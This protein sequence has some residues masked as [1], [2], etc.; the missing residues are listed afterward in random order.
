M[1]RTKFRLQSF[2]IALS[3]TLALFAFFW[4]VQLAPEARAPVALAASA[5]ALMLAAWG[6][7]WRGVMA[8]ITGRKRAE[9]SLQ[10]AHEALRQAN[11]ALA[12]IIHASP[13]AIFA[14]DLEG[15]VT[16]W[17]PAAER[18]FGWSREEALGRRL[19]LVED[20]DLAVF[21]DRI[22]RGKRGLRM[23][24]LEVTQR[25]K[26]GSSVTISMWTAP[27]RGPS[28]A[29]TGFIGLAADASERSLL[30]ERLRQSQKME[31]VGRLAGGVAHDF[32][33]LLTVITGYG[34]MLLDEI[35]TAESPRASV[36]E[37]LRTVERASALTSQLLTFSRHQVAQPVVLDLTSAVAKMD[38]ML[39]RVIGED[40]ELVAELSSQLG[41]VRADPAQIEQVILNLVVNARDAM[42]AG[43]R[44]AIR[45]A[46]L[47]IRPEDAL[48]HPAVSPGHYVLLSVADTG[49]GMDD[50]TKA[51]MF[52]PFFTT[53][54]HGK[55]TGLGM[56][57]VYAI[58]KRNAGEI[59]V[60]SQPG[61]G[62]TISI[63]LPRV[64]DLPE[65]PQEPSPAVCHERGTETILL[66][67][68]E[69]AV[70]KLVHEV[71]SQ[72]GYVVLQASRPEE[73]L[74]HSRRHPGKIDLLLTD[75]VMPHMSGRELAD[76]LAPAR[77]DM[78]VLF[79]SGYTEDAVVARCPQTALL[80]KPFTPA[81]LAHKVRTI[82]DNRP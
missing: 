25:R 27:L 2:L 57:T 82:L 47:E 14:F 72:H 11:E 1:L 49:Q 13:L 20:R 39:R 6:L 68:D 54:E 21:Q 17:N 80:K 8:D 7:L 77:S 33:N 51:H 38:R 41:K 45:T 22:E 66:V 63:Y 65:P 31:A 24:G 36:E 30:E 9:E 44:I 73:A 71:L 53:K 79:I 28:G 16:S 50:D 75:V 46:N 34:Y 32:N 81:A 15:N 56:S 10:T 26:D 69:D 19:P 43:G 62:A 76:R 70:R 29:P 3:A 58:V 4:C 59:L 74:Q 42:P 23:N 37:I 67:E 40:I 35:G 18:M 60:S 61:H 78:K 12:T 64:D 55:G 52:E 5:V 48:A